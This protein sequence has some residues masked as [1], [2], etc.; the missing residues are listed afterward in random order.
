M[1]CNICAH[2]W[3]VLVTFATLYKWAFDATSFIDIISPFMTGILTEI[4]SYFL[5][6]KFDRF[7]K[8]SGIVFCLV[9]STLMSIV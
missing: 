6:Q 8:I 2:V 5:V 4:Y 1:N 3:L 9:H 7:A